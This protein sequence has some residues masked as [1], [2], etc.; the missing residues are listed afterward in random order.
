MADE[1]TGVLVV[2][3]G[4]AGCCAAMFLARKGVRVLLV[5]RHEGPSI[6]PRATCQS[7]RTME[8]LRIG[9]VADEVL[10]ANATDNAGDEWDTSALSPAPFGRAAQD[11]VEPILLAQA[12]NAGA[13]IRFATEAVDLRQD[14]TGVT[15]RLLDGPTG[16]L[17]T[18]RADYLIAADGHRSPIRERLGIRRHGGGT[19]GNQIS[20]L[21]ST[22][23]SGERVLNFDYHPG[24]GESAADFT[25][26]RVIGLIR[27][28]LNAPDLAVRI[29]AVQAWAQG[30]WVAE[31][32]RTGRVFLAGDAAKA[33]PP[34]IGADTAV[35]DAYDL[36][37][38][39]ADVYT[40]AAQPT[41]LDSYDAERRPYATEVVHNT[42]TPV[43]MF[44]FRCRSNA[45][46]PQDDDTALTEDPDQPSGRPG[47]R[48]PHVPLVANGADVISTVDLFGDGW[49]LLTTEE[50]GLWRQA[51]ERVAH[52]LG[53][54]LTA[55]GPGPEL[56]DPTG[57]FAEVYGIDG[58][59][60]SLVRP[61][62]VVAWRCEYEV[63]DPAGT[64]FAVLRRLLG[65]QEA[66]QAA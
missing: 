34:G 46:I 37:W 45:V 44:G 3:A 14:A 66:V 43:S 54:R 51:A 50:G 1:R 41:L 65:H 7:P 36:A 33:A 21:F 38:K 35:A 24:R 40:G 64:L 11:Q 27:I 62:G 4:L 47:F 39:L 13:A 2:G 17:T 12:E 61:D 59:G 19:L 18:V 23:H 20:V 53:L 8:L 48:A 58:T 63:S 9:G 16:R 52:Q 49:T 15:A 57:G 25:P 30:E 60:A 55:Y 31:R 6:H 56:T 26:A 42:L 32:F 22:E 10:A 28:G 29:H 5:E